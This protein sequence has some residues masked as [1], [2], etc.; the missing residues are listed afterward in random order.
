MDNEGEFDG[1]V[2]VT[3]KDGSTVCLDFGHEHL[4]VL[5]DVRW[6]KRAEEDAG[7][8]QPRQAQAQLERLRA[9]GAPE[10]ELE[11]AGNAVAELERRVGEMEAM[12]NP[13]DDANG[14][15]AV[16]E[17]CLAY[18]IT[19]ERWVHAKVVGKPRANQYLVE[20]GTTDDGGH[21]DGGGSSDGKRKMV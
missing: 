13:T 21:G 5:L 8:R 19:D 16:G 6:V 18:S 11:R 9:D 12:L 4:T 3:Y 15:V 10:A 2:L 1:E 17:E 14:G 20:F 7:A